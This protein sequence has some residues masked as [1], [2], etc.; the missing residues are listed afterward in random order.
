MSHFPLGILQKLKNLLLDILFPPVSIDAV[1]IN[2]T[3]FC[4]TCR[5]RQA[6]NVKICHRDIPY[7]LAAATAYE[8]QVKD[9]ILALKYQKNSGVLQP[10]TDVLR[11]YISILELPTSN[12]IVVPI[13]MFPKKERQRGYNQAA[14]LSKEV[15]KILKIPVLENAIIKTR[16]TAAQADLKDWDKR[17]EN[18]KGLALY[19][20]Q[21]VFQSSSCN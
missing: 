17:K 11:K 2:Q 3:L 1:L 20:C 15:A 6:R 18:I 5:A 19:C 16:D 8:G 21:T 14:L 10:L 12:Y 13:P 9:W 4:P 7:K